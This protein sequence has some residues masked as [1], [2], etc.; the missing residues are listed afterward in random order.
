MRSV[1]GSELIGSRYDITCNM[2]YK[3]C[4]Y[5][6]ASASIQARFVSIPEGKLHYIH[7]LGTK[8]FLALGRSFSRRWWSGKRI[9]QGR[10]GSVH[11]GG[12]GWSRRSRRRGSWCWAHRG[13]TTC[14]GNRRCSRNRRRRS[15]ARRSCSHRRGRFG[16]W[17]R[18]GGRWCSS[19]PRWGRGRSFRCFRSSSRLVD[20]PFELLV[21]VKRALFAKFSF[22]WT[23]AGCFFL[24]SSPPFPEP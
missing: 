8:I 17:C 22:H 9:G 4:L 19:R 20:P 18:A 24:L 13:R 5:K 7:I 11:S 15:S 12:F 3:C 23:G 14:G 16:R 1:L 21:I 10:I 6:S 2:P